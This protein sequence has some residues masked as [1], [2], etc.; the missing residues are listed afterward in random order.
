MLP[1][2]RNAMA[3][4]GAFIFTFLIIFV[5]GVKFL[6]T[7]KDNFLFKNDV[8]I[9]DQYALITADV[10]CMRGRYKVID[11]RDGYVKLLDYLGEYTVEPINYFGIVSKIYVKDAY[12]CFDKHKNKDQ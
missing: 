2:E 5:F 8:K 3:L 9:G 12:G 6:V 7:N 1:K 4:K 11:V 10:F